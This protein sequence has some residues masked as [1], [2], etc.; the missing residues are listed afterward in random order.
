MK[1]KKSFFGALGPKIEIVLERT[2]LQQIGLIPNFFY[3]IFNL[4]E[5][6]NGMAYIFDCRYSTLC[7]Q[8]I[9]D[10]EGRVKEFD[11]ETYQATVSLNGEDIEP[12]IGIDSVI[13][14]PIENWSLDLVTP[15]TECV[16]KNGE[17]TKSEYP[18]PPEDSK[19]IPFV[20]D[21]SNI[22]DGIMDE[23]KVV[24]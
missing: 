15:S 19:V 5:E 4:S 22:P 3:P 21:S 1:N 9:T 16:R 23:G 2:L 6:Q 14:I 20:G 24:K 13:A 10:E 17:C 12:D 18:N 11:F 8:V 7:R